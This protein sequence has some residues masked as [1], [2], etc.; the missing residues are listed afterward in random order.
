LDE[1]RFVP[2]YLILNNV[3]TDPQGYEEYK[4]GAER[5]IAEHGG[6]YLVRGGVS[7]VPEGDWP[8]RFVVVEFPSYDAALAFY[9]SPEYEEL[10]AIRK[11]CSTS[12]V[13]IVDGYAG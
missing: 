10:S 7:T 3:V 13:A 2:G 6:R 1:H 9:R 5:L 11:R 4:A 8:T 12:S